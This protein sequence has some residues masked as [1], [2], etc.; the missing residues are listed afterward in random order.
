MVFFTLFYHVSGE[1]QAMNT[2]SNITVVKFT[3]N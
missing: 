1:F 2:A 3:N